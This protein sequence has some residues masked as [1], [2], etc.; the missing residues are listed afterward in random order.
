[1]TF[2]TAP[3][4]SLIGQTTFNP[5]PHLALN[6]HGEAVDG[7]LL[8]EF[9]GR[10]CYQSF[11]NPANRTT[12]EYLD[13]IRAQQ[14]LSV[15]EHANFSLY[16]EGVSRSL[17]HEFI[18]HR[19]LSPSQL[20]QRYVDES[21]TEFVIPPALLEAG[22]VLDGWKDQMLDLRD[23]YTALV[24]ALLDRNATDKTHARK[25]AREA[26]RS[27]L[28]NATETKLVMTGNARAWRHFLALR[29][30]LGADAEIRRLALEIYR[31]LHA[32]SP[33]LFAGFELQD[34]CLHGS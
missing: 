14:H 15:F 28:P 18:R 26:A 19:H 23:S 29:G 25:A 31:V 5:P 3:T 8:A 33:A 7:E 27:V 2:I 1:M 10:A 6:S 24:D 11:G 16:I 17:T 21:D 13:N 20:S 32:A 34:G 30:A 4:V 9:S 22:Y 12:R